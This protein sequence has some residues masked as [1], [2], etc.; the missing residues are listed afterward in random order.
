M[1]LFIAGALLKEAVFGFSLFLSAVAVY[2][3]VNR[4]VIGIY[5][6]KIIMQAIN[7]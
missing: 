2:I 6:K 7:R 1:V 4:K 3:F 5:G